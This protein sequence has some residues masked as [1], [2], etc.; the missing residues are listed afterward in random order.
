MQTVHVIQRGFGE[1]VHPDEQVQLTDEAT[2]QTYDLIVKGTAQR[3]S[4]GGT[5]RLY[6]PEAAIQSLFVIAGYYVVELAAPSNEAEAAE[7]RKRVA[8]A[9]VSGGSEIAS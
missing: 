7:R 5:V 2:G 8:Q 3:A 9:V 4:Q 6:I 1:Y